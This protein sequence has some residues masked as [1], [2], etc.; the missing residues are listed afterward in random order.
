M[1]DLPEKILQRLSSSGDAVDS[2]SLASEWGLDHQ[3]V[4]GAVKSLQCLD[5]V[6]RAEERSSTAWGLTAEGKEVAD[7]GSHE[8]VAFCAVPAEG[9]IPQPELM[10]KVH[11]VGSLKVSLVVP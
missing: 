2:L 6:V 9:G 3:K 4:V 10:K 8:F 11:K 7:K 1:M 5:A